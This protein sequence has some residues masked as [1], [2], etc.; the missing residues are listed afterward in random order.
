MTRKPRQLIGFT[1]V[2]LVI[3][4]AVLGILA[5]IGYV[6]IG[7]WRTRTAVNEV[8]ND[9]KAALAE[10]ENA[11]NFGNAYPDSLEDVHHEASPNVTVW[12][13]LRGDGSFCMDGVSNAVPSVKWYID[14]SQNSKLAEGECT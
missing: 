4:I 2:E 9:L 1:I 12:Y 14:S 7:D 3:I 6:A 5:A 8:Q 11:R 10:V 13:G